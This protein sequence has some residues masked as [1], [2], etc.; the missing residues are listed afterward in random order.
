MRMMSRRSISNLRAGLALCLALPLCAKPLT[1][2][3]ASTGAATTEA[4]TTISLDEAIRRAEANESGFASASA[5]SRASQLDRSIARAGLLPSASFHNQYLFT[6]GNGSGDRIGQT[7]N[8]PAPRF[9]AN[10]AV[11]EYASQ[12]VVNETVGLQQFSAVSLAD[13]NAAKAAAEMEIARRGLVSA[14]VTLYYGLISAETK[15]TAL[16]G[17]A[18]EAN[19]FVTLTQQREEARES[20]HADVVKAQLQQQ[21]RTRDLAD[22]QVSAT[23]ARLELGVLLFPDPRTAFKTEATAVPVLPDRSDIEADAAKNNAELKSALASLHASQAE[24]TSARAAYLPDLGLNFT[25]GVDAPQF[26]AK[27][28]DGARNLGYSASATL[29]I[30]LW[31]WLATQHKV[32]QSEIRRDAAKVALSAAQR[33]LIANLAEFYDEAAAARDQLAS[34]D[35][36]IMT[37]QESLRLTRLRYTGGEGTVFEVVDAQNTLL[38]AEAARADGAVRYQVALANLQTL[39]GRF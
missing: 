17:A 3:S 6:Q 20:A 37:A 26:A 22:A 36:S 8:A 30:P 15:L 19:H 13:A 7:A 29:D 21:Q 32:K 34:L 35:Q 27:G 4:T 18:D 23:R 31:D 12:G 25:Y 33:R 16:Q 1:A 14:V 38:S 9:I 24:V 5:E 2:Q 39:T 10:N 28:P 11:H